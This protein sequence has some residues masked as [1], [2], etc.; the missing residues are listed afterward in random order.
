MQ[1]RR[2]SRSCAFVAGRV[3]CL[4]K[5]DSFESRPMKT[6]LEAAPPSVERA[7]ID[8]WQA[9]PPS[10]SRAWRCQ[11]G[12]PVFF[13]NSR[14][15][16]C[17]TPLGFV[18]E[19]GSLLALEAGDAAGSWRAFGS[20][21]RAAGAA[22][23]WRCSNLDSAAGCNWLVAATD[24]GEP[25]LA[26]CRS[27][28]L[29]R[30]LPD[31][32]RKQHRLWWRRIELAKRRLVASLITLGLP[33]ASRVE[34]DPARGLAFDLLHEDEAHARVLSGYR[35]G[36]V[37]L[38]IEEADE[39]RRQRVRAVLH[40]PHRTL[41]GH[42][43]HDIGHYYWQRLVAG[44][45]WHAPFRE[46]FG[47]ERKDD[48]RT[49]QQLHAQQDSGDWAAR[50]VS[51]LA[52]ENPLEDW[53]ETFAHYLQ[54]AD[55][56]DTAL[57]FGIDAD[58]LELRYEPFNEASLYR[59]R[60]ADAAAFLGFVNRWMEL[61]GVLNELARSMGRPDFYPCVLSSVAVRKL[62]FVHLVILGTSGRSSRK[63]SPIGGGI[64]GGSRTG[65]GLS[66]GDGGGS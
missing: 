3:F 5:L 1:A 9:P 32:T 18:P 37:T 36:I 33:V 11:C 8:N 19:T 45:A 7:V 20:A 4:S 24:A 23:Y 22:L 25:G 61:T 58:N 12:R 66:A 46:L 16:G 55:A 63:V 59:R 13:R 10:R 56:L 14:C 64:T 40:Q 28:R 51:A 2:S 52:V 6:L 30:T 38:N 21:T 54:M 65:T 60:D 50:H 34:E 48:A 26:L 62:H 47:D 39:A 42:L 49:A 35:D 27:C 41:L 29:D 31:L 17:G 43:R 44:G 15:P 53:A 57:G